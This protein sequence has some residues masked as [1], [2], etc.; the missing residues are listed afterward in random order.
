M[1]LGF[2]ELQN[3]VLEFFSD[4][5]PDTKNTRSYQ[6]NNDFFVGNTQTKTLS[7]FLGDPITNVTR[8]KLEIYN[9]T[10]WED[11]SSWSVGQTGTTYSIMELMILE[12]LAGQKSGTGKYNG[13][14]QIADFD[15][16]QRIVYSTVN[17]LMMGGTFNA[18]QNTWAGTFFNL[19]VSRTNISF[20]TPIN[21]GS[22]TGGLPSG[23]GSSTSS[24]SSTVSFTPPIPEYFDNVTGASITG[25]TG[26]L[27]PNSLADQYLEVYRDG[28]KLRHTTDFTI[29]EGDNEIDL[30]L[31]AMGE[32]FEIKIY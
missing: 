5:K 26:T 11:A 22:S 24:G 21:S 3:P 8:G 4:G 12:L 23:S 16:H 7:G 20:G 29:D 28:R 13:S 6:A 10:S 31:Q 1:T 18:H 17:Y 27:P 14:F 2:W 15:F 30:V 32:Q 9:G 25:L 19:N